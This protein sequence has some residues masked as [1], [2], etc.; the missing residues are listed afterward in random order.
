MSNIVR[1]L[2][3]IYYYNGI[4]PL[5]SVHS[6]FFFCFDDISAS[7]DSFV[8]LSLMIIFELVSFPQPD[9]NT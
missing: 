2:V 7:C 5:H 3:C 8:Q 1:S 6:G 9:P 4:G